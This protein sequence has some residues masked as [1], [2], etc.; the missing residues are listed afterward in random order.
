MVSKIKMSLSLYNSGHNIYSRTSS[1]T[2]SIETP[3]KLR[4]YTK[5]VEVSLGNN[6]S[7][8]N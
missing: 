1:F 6:T 7:I 2:I 5:V 8:Q 3:A 4:L